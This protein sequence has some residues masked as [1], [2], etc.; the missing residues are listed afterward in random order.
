M[1]VVAPPRLEVKIC[2]VRTAADAAV[3]AAADADWAGL[4]RVASARRWIETARI[5]GVLAALAGVRPIL[6]VQNLDMRAIEAEMSAAGV[7]AVQ[8]HGEEQPT[9]GA[10]LRARGVFVVRA[11]H[12]A[13]LTDRALIDRWATCAD[14]FVLDGRRPGSGQTWAWQTLALAQ[15]RLAGVPVWLAGGLHPGNVAAAIHAVNPAGVDVASGV[16]HPQ[17]HQQDAAAITAFVATARAAR[18]LLSCN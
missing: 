7:R 12:A 5:P 3:C 1:T 2:G 4:N 13:H 8:L 11:L 18:S 9:L 17:T 16:E 15:G 6:V 14:R 10:A